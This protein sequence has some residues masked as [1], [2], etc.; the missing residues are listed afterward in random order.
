MTLKKYFMLSKFK[1]WL[2]FLFRSEWLPVSF[3][4]VNKSVE[5]LPFFYLNFIS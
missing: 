5:S 1:S 2:G 4:I 3:Y